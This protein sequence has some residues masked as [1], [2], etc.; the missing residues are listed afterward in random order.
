[1][2]PDT[3]PVVAI[4]DVAGTGGGRAELL[5]AFAE[6]ARAARAQPG[7]VRYDFAEAFDETDRFVLVSEWRDRAALDGHYASPAFERFQSALHGLL[8]RPSEMTL[9]AVSGIARPVPSPVMD[10]RDAD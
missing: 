2:T 1:M 3:E 9:Y 4:A 6:V 10:P 7:C 8:A 5:A